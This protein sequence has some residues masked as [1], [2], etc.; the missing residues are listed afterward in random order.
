MKRQC[1]LCKNWIEEKDT[2]FYTDNGVLIEGQP[3]VCEFCY[4]NLR[5]IT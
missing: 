3:S 5:R 1:V 4:L 2:N